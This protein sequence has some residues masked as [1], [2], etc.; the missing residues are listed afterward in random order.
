MKT[1]GGYPCDVELVERVRWPD[2]LHRAWTRRLIRR[3]WLRGLR[4][5]DVALGRAAA[6]VVA[7]LRV[8]RDRLARR[9]A[10]DERLARCGELD[11]ALRSLSQALRGVSA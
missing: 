7:A 8:L 1:A 3:A 6:R 11:V 5:E 4:V 10:W 2:R 9:L